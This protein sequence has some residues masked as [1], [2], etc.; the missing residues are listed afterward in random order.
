MHRLTRLHAARLV[1]ATLLVL[2]A[3]AP[4]LAP[5]TALADASK[6]FITSARENAMD[7]ATFP[8]HQGT[9]HG[10]AVYY[11][12]TDTS[13]GGLSSSLGV[14]TSPKLANAA[15]T[16]AVQHVASNNVGAISFPS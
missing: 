15:N 12:I 9:S 1:S 6:L 10:H 3:A 7:M 16:G 5:A 13:D 4:S 14:N 8:L 11:V 2:T